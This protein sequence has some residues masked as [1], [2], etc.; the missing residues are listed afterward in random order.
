M[1][2]RIGEIQGVVI[3][4]HG[5]GVQL[6]GQERLPKRKLRPAGQK[7]EFGGLNSVKTF[8]AEKWCIQRRRGESM[9]PSYPNAHI[10]PK[11][12]NER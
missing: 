4:E 3:K 7:S 9:A 2:Y 12:T 8:Q 5:R 11:P 6:G 1:C 10:H